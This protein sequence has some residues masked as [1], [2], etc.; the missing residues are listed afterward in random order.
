MKYLIKVNGKND[1]KF[2]YGAKYSDD[3]L[4]NNRREVKI[5]TMLEA[6]SG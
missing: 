1:H 3:L 6:P 4:S 5:Q 2:P